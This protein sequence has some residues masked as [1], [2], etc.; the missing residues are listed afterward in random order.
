LPSADGWKAGH[1]GSG[2]GDFHETGFYGEWHPQ[3][4][5]NFQTAENGFV[6][7]YRRLVFSF[8]LTDAT[9]NGWAL[10]DPDAV[11]I[12]VQCDDEFYRCKLASCGEFGQFFD[13]IVDVD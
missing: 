7:I 10:G 2:D 5:A 3:F 8:A 4:C 13:G 11:L 9:G 6:D 1:G 12:A